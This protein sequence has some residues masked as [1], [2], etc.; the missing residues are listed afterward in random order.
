MYWR[1]NLFKII[2][3][4]ILLPFTLQSFAGGGWTTDKHISGI[5]IEGTKTNGVALIT[6]EGGVPADKLPDS[7]CTSP[8]NM[9]SLQSEMGR[10]ILSVALAA[11][12]A[13]RKVRIA[14]GYDED[15][16]LCPSTRPVIKHIWLI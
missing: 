15:S 16:G 7:S 13:G 11:D 12:M 4:V 8:Y 9:V 5:L 3:L 1:L 10:G 6:L 14:L 2:L